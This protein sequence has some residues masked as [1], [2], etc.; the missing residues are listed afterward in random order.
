[1]VWSRTHLDVSATAGD[2]CFG[3]VRGTPPHHE[4][5]YADQRRHGRHAQHDTCRGSHHRV[6]LWRSLPLAASRANA[7]QNL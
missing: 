2:C 1:M 7:L 3:H 6:T 4:A 5:D